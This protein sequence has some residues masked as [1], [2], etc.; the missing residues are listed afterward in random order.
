MFTLVRIFLAAAGYGVCAGFAIIFTRFDGGLAAFWVAS[1]YLTALLCSTPRRDWVQITAA[2]ALVNVILTGTMGL[3]WVSAFPITAANLVEATFGASLIRRRTAHGTMD[4]L[5]WFARFVVKIGLAAPFVGAS[6]ASIAL[7]YT[8]GASLGVSWGTWFLG[9]ALGNIVFTPMFLLLFRG[10]LRRSFA[11]LNRSSMIELSLLMTLFIASCIFTFAQSRWP[12]LFFPL[13]PLA[14]IC[15]RHDRSVVALAI[16]LLALIGGVFTSLNSG[17]VSL[18]D[19]SI[20]EKTQFFQFYIAATVFTVIPIIADL[21]TRTR[22]LR[23]VR[24]S[25]KQLQLLLENSTDAVFHLKSSGE[26][27]FASPSVHALSGKEPAELIGQ[28]ALQLVDEDWKDYVAECHAEVVHAA[29]QS[30]RYEYLAKTANGDLRWFETLSQAIVTPT[31]DVESVVSVVRDIDERKRTEIS[32]VREARVDGL[33]GLLNRNGFQQKF[34]EITLEGRHCIAVADL[35]HFK[36]INDRFGHAAGDR[37]LQ[38]FADVALRNVRK[39][40]LVARFGGEEFVILLT[41]MSYEEAYVACQRL[42]EEI[43]SAITFFGANHIQFTVSIG[44]AELR[45]SDLRTELQRADLA[46]YQAK[47]EGR[48]C[49]RRAA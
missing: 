1:A 19:V 33:T 28:N 8:V 24:T 26:V 14:L 15:F 34:D 22:L 3:G 44:L 46:L 36:S 39:R 7:V 37:A 5:D 29:G 18:M 47:R 12:L 41:D 48:D 2:C 40:D 23:A 30:V 11:G 42:R 43:G 9:H 4:S 25:E 35:D 16:A 20:K 32:L 6:L 17:P 38:T 45:S 31:G 10:D 49:L 13:G 27:I 21:R